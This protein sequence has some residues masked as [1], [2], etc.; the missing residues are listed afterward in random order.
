MDIIC[1]YISHFI[2]NGFNV[3]DLGLL[4]VVVTVIILVMRYIFRAAVGSFTQ[5]L[6]CPLTPTFQ[7]L[8]TWMIIPVGY[9]NE[10]FRRVS[11]VV[12]LYTNHLVAS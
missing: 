12:P 9:R 8:L 1:L 5:G 4:L 6:L 7:R 11:V 2:R 3:D 10:L